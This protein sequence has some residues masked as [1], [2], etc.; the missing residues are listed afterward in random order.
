[1]FNGNNRTLSSDVDKDLV[2]VSHEKSLFFLCIFYK[3]M[4]IKILKGDTTRI[5]T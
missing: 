3:Y 4:Q 5:R 2:S 1:M